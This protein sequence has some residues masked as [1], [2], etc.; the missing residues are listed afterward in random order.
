MYHTRNRPL[1]A[2]KLLPHQ[3][4]NFGIL[5]SIASFFII[6]I[7][8]NLLAALFSVLGLLFYV[9]VYTRWLK[10]RTTQNAIISGIAWAAPVLV[11]WAAGSGSLSVGALLLFGVIVYWA[12]P[13]YWAQGM[14]YRKDYARAGVPL[15][16]VVHG[17]RPARS[18]VMVYA[19]MTFLLS[20]VPSVIGMLYTFYGVA[21]L[22]LGG[23]FVIF[24]LYM[25]MNPGVRP[26]INLYRFTR[27]YMPL[28][29]A[30]MILDRIAF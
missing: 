30:A 24:A 23:L 26:A 6:A 4:L 28:L 14:I 2:Q 21:A 13:Y 18:Q 1:P 9:V 3:A 17:D 25:Y 16:P 19:V 7:G 29:F 20:L 22:S 11:G 27:L 10:R 5:L 15:L 12:P 8:A